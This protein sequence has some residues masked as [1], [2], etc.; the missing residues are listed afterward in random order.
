[1]DPVIPWYQTQLGAG[2]IGGLVTAV[3]GAPLPIFLW[4][5]SK[6]Y[7]RLSIGTGRVLEIGSDIQAL[8]GLG[9]DV[10]L[11]ISGES[12]AAASLHSFIVSNTGTQTIKAQPLRFEFDSNA[13]V[14]GYTLEAANTELEDSVKRNSSPAKQNELHLMVPML[15]VKERIRVQIMVSG[16]ESIASSIAA[17]NDGV[18]VHFYQLNSPE[19][20]FEETSAED[21]FLAVASALPFVG[22]FAYS[23]LILTLAGRLEDSIYSLGER[24]DQLSQQPIKFETTLPHAIDTDSTAHPNASAAEK[25]GGP[26]LAKKPT[27]P[28]P[29]P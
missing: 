2:V 23:K 27:P 4:L 21:R 10:S 25:V 28:A 16:T 15:L 22:G 9:I 17:R 19:S 24:V 1:M 8:A 3:L 5:R 29:V 14:H 20:V 18:A 6:Q 12:V 13:K 26:P 11:R 7:S